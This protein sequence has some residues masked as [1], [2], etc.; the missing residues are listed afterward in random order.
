MK[1][2]VVY[3]RPEEAARN[4]GFIKLLKLAAERAGLLLTLSMYPDDLTPDSDF[5]IFRERNAKLARELENSGHRLF[6]R[7]KINQI[8]NDKYATYQLATFMGV[9]A[10]PSRLVDSPDELDSYPAVL[11]TVDG[12]GGV[13]VARVL[14]EMEAGWF[15]TRFMDR[16]IIGQPFIES[17]AADVRLFMVGNEL[18]GAVKRTGSTGFKSNYTLGGRVDPYRPTADMVRAAQRLTR[19][20]KSDYIGVDFLLLPDGGFLLNEIE[21]PVGARSL[22]E[23]SDV[24]IADVLMQHIKNK[25]NE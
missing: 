18:A 2:G 16:R 25:L 19:A 11:K 17:G 9:P 10:V 22:Y 24:N 20:L 13:E 4:V 5:I 14:D 23:T 8:A 3:Y 6:N 7:A 12:H 1:H 21:D 15:F